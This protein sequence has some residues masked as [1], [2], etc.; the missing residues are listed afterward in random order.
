MKKSRMVWHIYPYVA[1][2]TLT[3]LIGAAVV[4]AAAMKSFHLGQVAADLERA[5]YM[6]RPQI[7]QP[8]I[9]GRYAAVQE[10]CRSAGT[11]SGIRVTVMLPDG[12]VVGDSF[13]SPR[14]MDNHADRPEIRTARFGKVGTAVRYS[15]TLTQRMMYVAVPV[16]MGSGVVGVLRTSLSVASIDNR[17]ASVQWRIGIGAGIIAIVILAVSILVSRRIS[18][19]IEEL[20]RG[21]DR[22][23]AGD[24][25]HR[26]PLPPSEE[27]ATLAES[28]NQMAARLEDRIQTI[29]RQRNDLEAVLSSMT[30]GVLAIDRNEKVIFNNNA[31]GRLLGQSSGNLAGRSLH[32]ILR[33]TD[34][35]KLA[36][37]AL[38]TG[39]P[40]A[41]DLTLFLDRERFV[42]V[43]SAPLKDADGRHIGTVF[44]LN[45]VTQIRLLEGMRRDFAANV[46]HEIRTPITAIKGFVE[47]LSDDDRLSRSESRR[48]LGII[49]RHVDRLIAIIEDL[50][51]LSRI[52]QM[53]GSGLIERV[54][55]PLL[56]IIR[57]AVS[58]C[59][60]S[61]AA[62]TIAIEVSCEETLEAPV[63]VALLERALAN[64]LNN[65]VNYTEPGGRIGVSAGL[66]P[67]S[68]TISV[69]DTGI[70]IPQKHLPRIFERFYRVDKARSRESGG[71]GLGLA[72]VKH[73]ALAHGGQVTVRSTPGKGSRFAMRLPIRTRPSD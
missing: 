33:S 19:P 16:T 44:V 43:N 38:A 60:D 70:G 71:T 18:R 10:A 36:Q 14:E 64:L 13:N 20:K 23:S 69:E 3:C 27:M 8:L 31:V 9:D 52:E 37:D 30:E 26:L 66:A 65:A 35:A 45:D 4:M 61:A 41:G 6:V 53:G 25:S 68:I 5:A 2:V 21:A 39:K 42:R 17:M 48:F 57:R 67:D 73:I 15:T 55:T 51:S 54:S 72:I 28:M 40:I 56:P 32:E 1:G 12:R 7:A 58:A 46:S 29:V 11:A 50:I 49:H 62:K 24:L 34:F 63:N 47:T 22:F 59:S